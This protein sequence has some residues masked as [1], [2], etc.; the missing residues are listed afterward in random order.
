MKKTSFRVK[1]NEKVSNH[2]LQY[3]SRLINP[4]KSTNKYLK[5]YAG[6]VNEGKYVQW[7]ETKNNFF[8]DSASGLEGPM[9][10]L[11]HELF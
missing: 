6:C 2:H 1:I 5:V 4:Y 8:F 9:A 7:S 3:C 11:S 10:L